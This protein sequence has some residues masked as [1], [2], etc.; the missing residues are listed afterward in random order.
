M[1]IE[2]LR[3][4]SSYVT[5]TAQ[6]LMDSGNMNEA[7]KILKGCEKCLR[8]AVPPDFVYQ[9]GLLFTLNNFLAQ[10][11]NRMAD[12]PLS[13]KYLET[14]IDSCLDPRT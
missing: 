13:I 11:A 7:K 14:A 12:V 8:T 9:L 1:I 2:S 10:L 4:Y 5:E 3:G 6:N